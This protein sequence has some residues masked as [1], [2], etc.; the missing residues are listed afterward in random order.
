MIKVIFV[1]LGNICRSP[2]ADAVFQKLVEDA[3]LADQIM[4]DSA[5]TSRYEVGKRAHRGTLKILEEHGMTYLG[6]ARQLTAKDLERFDYV[7]AMDKSNLSRIQSMVR[8]QGET[9]EVRLF[10]SYAHKKQMV[11][12]LEVPDPYYDG[13]FDDVYDLVSKGCQALLEHIRTEH[14][15]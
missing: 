5:A 12:V 13:R 1:C 8:G 7:L 10:L 11:N 14:D 15:I 4:V 9:A 3:G 6:S 2:M